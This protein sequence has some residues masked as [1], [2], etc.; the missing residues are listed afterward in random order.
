ML[1]I[2]AVSTSTQVYTNVTTGSLTASPLSDTKRC[3]TGRALSHRKSM[4]TAA[5]TPS[6]TTFPPM[7][8][9][10]ALRYALSYQ[11]TRPRSIFDLRTSGLNLRVGVGFGR[12]GRFVASCLPL[13][14]YLSFLLPPWFAAFVRLRDR[15][16]LFYLLTS[17]QISSPRAK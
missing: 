14:V 9:G 6:T 11:P 12:L 8:I 5:G 16:L 10:F 2:T 3:S 4:T 7:Q 13:S 17:E 1:P 15:L